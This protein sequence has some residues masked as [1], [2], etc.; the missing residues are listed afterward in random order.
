MLYNKSYQLRSNTMQNTAIK[1]NL[2]LPESDYI[3]NNV[4]LA[5][6]DKNMQIFAALQEGKDA[7]NKFLPN[8]FEKLNKCCSDVGVLLYSEECNT[9]ILE[10]EVRS[11]FPFLMLANIPEQGIQISN[12]MNYADEHLNPIEAS[13]V[14]NVLAYSYLCE[15]S[16]D[17]DEQYFSAFMVDYLKTLSSKNRSNKNFNSSAFWRVID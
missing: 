14:L 17:E 11:G 6:H 3:L 4:Y 10:S 15:K 16:T 2:S 9:F 12:R 8:H 5:D 7:I 13:M 1:F